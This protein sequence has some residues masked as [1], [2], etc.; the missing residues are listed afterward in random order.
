[1]T[2]PPKTIQAGNPVQA[3]T[4]TAREDLKGRASA[5]LGTLSGFGIALD[6]E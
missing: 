1:M 5:A 2:P 3:S 6:A 4:R